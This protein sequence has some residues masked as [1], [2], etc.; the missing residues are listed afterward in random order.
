MTPSPAPA[1]L[2]TV[3]ISTSTGGDYTAAFLGGILS[4]SVVAV[5]MSWVARIRGAMAAGASE[6]YAR[7]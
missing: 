1:E 6:A 4:A 3:T 2:P 5:G 7:V